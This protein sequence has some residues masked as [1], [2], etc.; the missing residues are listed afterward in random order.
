MAKNSSQ[1]QKANSQTTTSNDT[2]NGTPSQSSVLKKIIQSNRNPTKVVCGP[3]PLVC[4]LVGL[5]FLALGLVSPHLLEGYKKKTAVT[6]QK[7]ARPPKLVEANDKVKAKAETEK[8]KKRKKERRLVEMP[9]TPGN[10]F[11]CDAEALAKVLHE[12][13]VPGM[14]VLCMSQTMKSLQLTFFKDAQQT[15]APPRIEMEGLPDWSSFKKTLAQYLSLTPTDELHQEWSMYSPNGEILVQESNS[16]VEMEGLVQMGMVIIFQGGQFI[17]PGV[18]IGFKRT[19][20]LYSVMPGGSPA[21]GDKKRNATL[22]TLSLEPLVFS[23]EGF[24]DDTECDFFQEEA[25]PSMEYSEVT[26]MDIDKGRPASDFRTSQSTFLAKNDHPIVK[27]I[28]YRTA[29]LVRVP[30]FHQENVQ[31]LRYGG[32]EKYDA[33]HDYFDKQLY[34]NDESTLKNFIQYGRRNRMITVFWYLSNVEEG[35][36]TIFPRAGGAPP[37]MSMANCD[38]GL[39]VKPSRGKV[40]IFY[41]LKADGSLDPMSLHGACPVKKGIKWAANKWVWNLPIEFGSGR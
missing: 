41:S 21:M 29:S 33:H 2:D 3:P 20:E 7:S 28:D 26:L 32:G 34:Q 25:A 30:R 5:L 6:S 31:V 35:G 4:L 10:E 36:E 40:I 37:P 24:L 8:K 39:K 11:A 12:N 22:E 27:D 15:D 9:D 1:K 17:W 19:I 13:P 16:Y 38:V 23:V 14:H 18:R